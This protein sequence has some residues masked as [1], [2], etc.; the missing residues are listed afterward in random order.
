MVIWI[1]T[2]VFV[3]IRLIISVISVLVRAFAFFVKIPFYAIQASLILM[4]ALMVRSSVSKI[5]SIRPNNKY[6][7]VHGFNF[8]FWFI[9]FSLLAYGIVVSEIYRKNEEHR[10]PIFFFTV[11]ILQDVV[12]TCIDCFLMWQ[13]LRY[14]R[15]NKISN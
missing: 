12:E 8:L 6:V 2:S 7:Y 9:L 11:L 10:K 5:P 15:G 4:G 13:V 1:S 3:V 14:A